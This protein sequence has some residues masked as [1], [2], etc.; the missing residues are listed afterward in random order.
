MNVSIGACEPGAQTQRFTKEQTIGDKDG[1]NTGKSNLPDG[2]EVDSD[3][4]QTPI[5]DEVYYI[6]PGKVYRM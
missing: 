4:A 2:T 3:A 6:V 5:S 1:T